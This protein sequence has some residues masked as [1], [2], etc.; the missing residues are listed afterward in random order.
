VIDFVL[1]DQNSTALQEALERKKVPFVI[2]TGYPAVLV[3]RYPQQTI[4]HKPLSSR[5]L[6]S[7]LRA[8]R[9]RQEAGITAGHSLTCTTF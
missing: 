9:Q 3:R 7:T 1:E 6:C 2:V 5:E 8:A 4:L